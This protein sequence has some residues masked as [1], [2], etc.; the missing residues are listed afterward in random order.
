MRNRFNLNESEKSR[1]RD[2]HGM[3][4]INEQSYDRREEDSMEEPEAL[5]KSIYEKLEYK[6]G[7]AKSNVLLK[8]LQ[9]I[10]KEV[11]EGRL[12]GM[13]LEHVLQK[14][15][16]TLRGYKGD[17]S[18]SGEELRIPFT[19]AMRL[20]EEIYEEIDL[21]VQTE[22]KQPI[23]EQHTPKSVWHV[24]EKNDLISKVDD[25]HRILTT[26]SKSWNRKE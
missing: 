3:Q 2:L 19:K 20:L 13:D 7:D 17:I 1:I 4:V 14:L 5:L 26:P 12:R 16:A 11:R 25:I 8:N 6:G 18:A 23:K 22:S 9:K 10:E 21:N 15:P 24:D